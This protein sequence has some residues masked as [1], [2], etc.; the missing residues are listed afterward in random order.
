MDYSTK[1]GKNYAP[2][3]DVAAY[4]WLIGWLVYL[5]TTR[6]D[7]SFSV[8]KLSHYP[9]CPTTTHYHV[10]ICVL[11]Y[12]KQAP[13]A[14]LFFPVS[15]DLVLS[16]Y[17]D[18]DWAPCIDTRRSVSGFC[19]YLGTSLVSWKSKKQH[20]IARSSLEVEYRALA[21]AT[22][23]AQW[24]SYILADLHMPLLNSIPLYYDSQSARYIA[25]NPIF[26]E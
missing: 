5:T 17:S 26:H 21:L 7:I 23:E 20:T 22:C 2:Y 18:T 9:D 25:T 3:S 13:V 4:R 14:G 15:S 11:R 8:E 6:L 10:S 19:F 24:I 12:L 1:L 16:G